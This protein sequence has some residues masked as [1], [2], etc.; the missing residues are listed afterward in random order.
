MKKLTITIIVLA[1]IALAVIMYSNLSKNR[2]D[3]NNEGDTSAM[4]KSFIDQMIP[5]HQEAVL[6]S[7]K[8]MNDLE[9]TEPKV[10]IFAANVVDTQTFEIQKMKNV[11]TEYYKQ[12]YEEA[13]PMTHM[14]NTEG[15]KGDELAKQYTKDMIKH[16]EAAV[17]MAKDYIKM[18]DKVKKASSV[19]QDGLTI[20]NTHPAIDDTYALA[21]QIV[22]TQTKEIEVLKSWYK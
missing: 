6:S 7:L 13:A 17:D 22:D 15:L 12:E 14:M 8:V 21:K 10:R 1:L 19:T 3:L 9:I 5:H 16:H 4:V 11:Y 18:I 2:F 20:T